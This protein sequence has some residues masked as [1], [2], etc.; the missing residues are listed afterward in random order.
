MELG[1]GGVDPTCRKGGNIMKKIILLFVFVFAAYLTTG[2]SAA[3]A[4]LIE[5]GDFEL[6]LTNWDHSPNVKAKGS[7]ANID[8]KGGERQAVLSPSGFLPSELSQG[9]EID[10]TGSISISFD[11]NL[12]SFSSLGSEVGDDFVVTLV[13]D[14]SVFF[15]EILRINFKD[16]LSQG[17]TI[18]GWQHYEEIF[19]FDTLMD[20]SLLFEAD[21]FKDP[22]QFS[23]GF[24]DNVEVSVVPVPPSLLLLSSG[25]MSIGVYFRRRKIF[26]DLSRGVH[27]TG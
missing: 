27:L 23:I 1:R 25:L 4:Y 21:N 14:D 10:E 22:A 16:T 9:F 26:K 7:W 8:P 18:Q 12:W 3:K 17:P 11:Y 2:G 5:N 19:Q 24:V 20:I 13:S 15:N 6:G